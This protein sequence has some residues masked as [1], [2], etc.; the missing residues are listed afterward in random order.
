MTRLTK[1]EDERVWKL[2]D[3]S[4]EQHKR[5]YGCYSRMGVII[6]TPEQWDKFN[7]PLPGEGGGDCA[8][9]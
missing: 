8:D 6:M 5:D 7:K 1:E 2:I 9:T 4:M 3:D